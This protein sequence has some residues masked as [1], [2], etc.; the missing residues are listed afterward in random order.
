VVHK[1]AMANQMTPFSLTVARQ[2]TMVLGV[3]ASMVEQSLALLRG[4][5][6]ADVATLASTDRFKQALQKL[7]APTDS[8]FFVDVS[9]IM[10]QAR[11]FA[12]MVEDMG[13][14]TTQE[15]GET[16]TQPA[17]KPMAFLIPLLN[18]LDMWE[19]AASVSTTDGMKTMTDEVTALRRRPRTARCTRRFT[20][21]ARSSNR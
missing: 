3:G 16:A 18:E 7:P 10:A 8:I 13:S 20:A 17:A 4:E 21:A 11:V 6:K 5:T 14:P 12:K 2:K 1:L 19:Y 15:S 9:K